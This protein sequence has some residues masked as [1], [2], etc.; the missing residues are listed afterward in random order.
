MNEVGVHVVYD[1]KYGLLWDGDI[2]SRITMHDPYIL[3]KI[4]SVMH[5][6]ESILV[7]F[8]YFGVLQSV[9][10]LANMRLLRI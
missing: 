6:Y 8:R 7:A 3:P 5:A 10:L 2:L 1:P 4:R 9:Y